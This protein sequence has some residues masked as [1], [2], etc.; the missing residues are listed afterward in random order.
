MCSDIRLFSPARMSTKPDVCQKKRQEDKRCPMTPKTTTNLQPLLG[1]STSAAATASDGT[2]DPVESPSSAGFPEIKTTRA[3]A[4]TADYDDR[5]V[6]PTSPDSRI[7]ENPPC[8]PAPMKLKS[9]PVCKRR[10]SADHD[11]NVRSS[12]RLLDFCKEVESMFSPRLQHNL[13]RKIK[14][15]RSV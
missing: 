2:H 11:T 1:D 9:Q 6:T 12:S 15:A 13:G 10:R 3:T 5:P 8:P 14:K 4:A 7:P